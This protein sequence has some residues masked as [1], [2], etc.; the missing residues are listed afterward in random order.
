MSVWVLALLASSCLVSAQNHWRWDPKSLKFLGEKKD[1]I[2]AKLLNNSFTRSIVRLISGKKHDEVTTSPAMVEEDTINDKSIIKLAKEYIKNEEYHSAIQQL[3][4]LVNRKEHQL[5]FAMIGASLMALNRPKL[6]EG[7]LYQAV[8]MSNFTDITSMGNLVE[9]LRLAEKENVNQ[10]EETVR[11]A[12][13]FGLYC[14][15]S[16][17]Q[18]NVTDNTGL[19]AYSLGS[20]Y[21]DGEEYSKAADYFLISALQNPVNVNAWIRAST[22]K[23]SQE[24]IDLV[25]AENVLVKALD[26]PENKESP[27]LYYELGSA[28]LQGG[29]A[30]EAIVLFETAASYVDHPK[31]TIALATAYH[32][33]GGLSEAFT[34][35]EKVMP[36]IDERVR[37]NSVDGNDILTI[38]NFAKLMCHANV[39]QFSYGLDLASRALELSKLKNENMLYAQSAY[40]DCVS[41]TT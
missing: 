13:K 12:E 3:L 40:D 36:Y 30:S 9:V 15:N 7:F 33:N 32:T 20:M 11:L 28:L 27:D 16:L 31:I 1:G 17:K 23:F 26:Y 29:R 14:M 34:N 37:D 4:G 18:A 19:I 8:I 41:L 22:M 38:T 5:A 10:D 35:Y 24:N 39:R 2:L 21:I 25:F 6:A